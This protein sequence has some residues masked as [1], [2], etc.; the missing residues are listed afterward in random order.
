MLYS[1]LL[2]E[3]PC[4]DVR[5]SSASPP[6]PT[7]GPSLVDQVPHGAP[8]LGPSE[9]LGPAIAGAGPNP[10]ST[11]A[12]ASAASY[13]GKKGVTPLYPFL[14]IAKSI[15]DYNHLLNALYVHK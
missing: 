4:A 5:A 2:K 6:A 1:L 11:A 8:T 9:A 15:H 12:H 3:R 7:S 14:K 10:G 13:R